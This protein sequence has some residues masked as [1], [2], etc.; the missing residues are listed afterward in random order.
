M[1]LKSGMRFTLQNDRKNYYTI[2]LVKNK[3]IEITPMV[4]VL[5]PDG[6]GRKRRGYDYISIEECLDHIRTEHW[7]LEDEK[8]IQKI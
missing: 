5:N 8:D 7:R 6:I 3:L 2:V 4:D 1:E